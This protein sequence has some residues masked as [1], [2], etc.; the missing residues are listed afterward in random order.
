MSVQLTAT[1]TGLEFK[2]NFTRFTAKPLLQKKDISGT[3]RIYK[4]L[5]YLAAFDFIATYYHNNTKYEKSVSRFGYV[6]E[7]D[8]ANID[9]F[10]G[11][12]EDQDESLQD[13]I[14]NVSNDGIKPTGFQTDPITW[15][16]NV[17][18]GF[19]EI[20]NELVESIN[21]QLN[22]QLPTTCCLDCNHFGDITNNV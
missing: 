10:L 7:S 18:G 19:D 6:S 2:V 14:N 9:Q 8:S 3:V 4:N 5:V 21:K 17:L 12:V 22:P 13:N 20:K 11:K 16:K 1:T 15:L